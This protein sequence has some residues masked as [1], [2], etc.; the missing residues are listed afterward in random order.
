MRKGRPQVALI[1]TTE[2][3]QRLE[4]LRIVCASAAALARRARILDQ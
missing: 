1:L 2:E 3:R 4:S